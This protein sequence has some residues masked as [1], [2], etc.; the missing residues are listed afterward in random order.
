MD[1]DLLEIGFILGAHG[2]RGGLRVGLHD[3]DSDAVV[4]GRVLAVLA[5]RAPTEV[6]RTRVLQAAAVP[7]QA[8]KLR[9]VLE[10]VGDRNQAE[11]LKGHR[12]AARRED[13]PTL[14]EDE[15]YLADAIGLPV[16][17]RRGEGLQALGTIVG[18][19]S[20]GAQDLF[21]VEWRRPSGRPEVW[22]LPVLPGFL[23]EV[24]PSGVL[25][26]LPEGM[27]PDELESP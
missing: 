14:A 4:E 11:M 24:E 6:L 21:E 16:A 5:P 3:P 17:R 15:F 19:T 10:G 9:V 2:I 1:E 26:D 8:G 13:L 7:G 18:F 20:N 23:L 25:V 22:L 12:L 27:L